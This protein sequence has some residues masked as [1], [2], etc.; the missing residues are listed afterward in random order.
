MMMMDGPTMRAIGH[1][2]SNGWRGSIDQSPQP[3]TIPTETQ[4]DR[5]SITPI[6][7]SRPPFEPALTSNTHADYVK[8][9]EAAGARAVPLHY[10]AP[11]PEI[12]AV[13]QQV[14]GVIFPG[15]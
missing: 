10:D 4:S 14:N 15:G 13:L 6:E 2:V 8:W 1:V 12:D 7:C 11:E 9:I 5:P 3:P